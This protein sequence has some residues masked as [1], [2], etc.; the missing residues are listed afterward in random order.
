MS[1]RSTAFFHLHV[2]SGLAGIRT[3]VIGSEGRKDNPLPYKPVRT[4][5]YLDY[6]LFILQNIVENTKDNSKVSDKTAKSV[7]S[8]GPKVVNISLGKFFDNIVF[9]T[10]NLEESAGKIESVVTEVLSRVLLDGAKAI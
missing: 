1:Y 9:N 8:S 10:T 3:R 2:L 5:I 4:I 7:A 6:K